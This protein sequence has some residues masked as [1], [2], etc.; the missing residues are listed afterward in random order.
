MPITIEQLDAIVKA[1]AS[2]SWE[3]GALCAFMAICVMGVVWLVKTW[4]NQAYSR[5]ERMAKRIDALE[6]FIRTELRTVATKCQ[7]ALDRNTAATNDLVKALADRVCFWD[8]AHQ[9]H[10]LDRFGKQL[11]EKVAQ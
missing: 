11:A 6:D 9:D 5:E 2:R 4:L 7:E 1:A 8:A 3:A 10:L